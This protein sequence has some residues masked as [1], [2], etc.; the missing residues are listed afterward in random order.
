MSHGIDYLHSHSG[1]E[2]ELSFPK[3]IVLVDAKYKDL[4]KEKEIKAF[5]YDGIEYYKVPIL[6]FVK[7]NGQFKN[8]KA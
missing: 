1:L 4:F 3:N 7:K 2:R 8:L 6:S 5:K